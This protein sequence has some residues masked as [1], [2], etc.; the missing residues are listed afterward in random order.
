[1]N[2]KM[3]IT[4]K[5]RVIHKSNNRGILKIQ[6]SGTLTLVNLFNVINMFFLSKSAV[7]VIV[8]IIVFAFAFSCVNS[9]HELLF[10]C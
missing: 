9:S 6:F 10:K 3:R 2:F 7:K 4:V 8:D 5:Y 1:M